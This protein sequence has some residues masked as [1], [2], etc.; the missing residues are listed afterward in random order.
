[1][2][3]LRMMSH[4]GVCAAIAAACTAIVCFMPTSAPARPA[5]GLLLAG[6]LLAWSIG[7]L[8]LSRAER[9]PA[10]EVGWA[11]ACGFAVVA[12]LAIGF[13]FATSIGL[14]ATPMAVGLL[15]IVCSCD[16]T[17]R[18]IARETD[19]ER[20]FDLRAS[21]L[22]CTGV[23]LGVVAFVIAHNGAVSAS[24]ART[25]TSAS[26]VRGARGYHVVLDNPTSQ[27]DI[28]TIAISP[29]RGRTQY[30]TLTLAAGVERQLPVA[31]GRHHHPIRS[32]TVVVTISSRG[33]RGLT[34]R[35]TTPPGA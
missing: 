9:R 20:P 33:Q 5:A 4:R 3:S 29:K 24:R 19:T 13:T 17:A 21:V 12:V 25:T 22:A 8:V 2:S 1:M 10:V 18:P 15:L 32:F 16:L 31:R 11:V 30:Q 35:L 28:L 23:A 14:K 27:Q 34:L 7:R 26:L 6:P